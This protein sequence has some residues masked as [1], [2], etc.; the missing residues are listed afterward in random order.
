MNFMIQKLL[1]SSL[2]QMKP[3][4]RYTRGDGQL[5]GH[6]ECGATPQITSQETIV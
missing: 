5:N 2:N 4:R 1:K 6:Q 3:F